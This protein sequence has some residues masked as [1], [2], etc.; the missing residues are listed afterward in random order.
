[1]SHRIVNPAELSK[2]RGF[3]HAV[4]AA[5]GRTVHFGGQTSHDRDGVV[6]GRSLAEQFDGAAANLALALRAAGAEPAHLVSMQIFVT[7]AAEYRSSLKE[8]GA[9]HRRHFGRHF[10]A[11]ALFEVSGLADPAARVE[12]LAVAVIPDDERQ[13]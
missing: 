4:V 5:P 9:A 12:L 10:P 3:S 8:V 13:Q 1:M 7:D 11:M 2:P 6:Q